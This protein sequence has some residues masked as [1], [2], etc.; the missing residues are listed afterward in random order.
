MAANWSLV[1]LLLV[2]ATNLAWSSVLDNSNTPSCRFALKYT[3]SSILDDP[4]AFEAD[5]MYWEGMFH[6]NNVSYNAINGMTFDGTLLNPVTG[7]RETDG[8]HTF[9]AASKESLHFMILTHVILGEPRAVRW[10]L[11]AHGGGS[12]VETAREIAFDI[13]QN[14][15]DSYSYFNATFPGFGGFLPW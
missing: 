6:Q 12:D 3:T 14:K 1:S 9:S 4:D 5:V 11:A 13:L 8:L 15:W 2:Y 7:V 10:I